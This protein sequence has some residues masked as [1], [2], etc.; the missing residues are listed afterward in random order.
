MSFDLVVAGVMK[1]L[2][3]FPFNIFDCEH[4]RITVLRNS[5]S[6]RR[7]SSKISGDYE[8]KSCRSQAPP[9]PP[10]PPS[11]SSSGQLTLEASAFLG[12]K[13]N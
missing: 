4:S 12:G 7:L 5:C 6:L 9:T 13:L 2:I 1:A 3:F 8:N 11:T 10:P